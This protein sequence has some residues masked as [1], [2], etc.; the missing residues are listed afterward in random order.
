MQTLALTVN[1]M[2]RLELLAQALVAVTAPPPKVAANAPLMA[3]AESP[4][5]KLALVWLPM[6]TLALPPPSFRIAVNENDF[7]PAEASG[8]FTPGADHAIDEYWPSNEVE[9]DT[10]FCSCVPAALH[11][12]VCPLGGGAGV[13][14]PPPPGDA[15]VGAAVAPG[16]GNFTVAVLEPDLHAFALHAV[17]WTAAVVSLENAVVN[18]VF[19]LNAGTFTPFSDHDTL[20]NAPSILVVQLN[21][22]LFAAGGA[23]NAVLQVTA[24]FAGGGTGVGVAVGLAVGLPAPF[25]ALAPAVAEPEGEGLGFATVAPGGVVPAGLGS[26]VFPP[27]GTAPG[28][29]ETC[30]PFAGS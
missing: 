4:T 14:V 11:T 21:V 2:V 19:P 3:P 8:G 5:P 26:A 25:V 9:Q 7:V 15:V 12:S 24:T 29:T 18:A 16:G 22:A 20:V 13:G 17:T 10:V 23:E 28:T 30:A 27:P 6:V 1:T